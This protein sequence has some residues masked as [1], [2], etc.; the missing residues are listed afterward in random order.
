MPSSL[1]L[2]SVCL[3]TVAAAPTS[4]R[5]MVPGGLDGYWGQQI[6]DFE[7][8]KLAEG[9]EVKAGQ[10]EASGGEGSWSWFPAP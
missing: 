10:R 6:A 8:M 9:Q 2:W 4:V 5:I 3:G 7:S 1:M